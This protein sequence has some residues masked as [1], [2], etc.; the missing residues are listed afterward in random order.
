MEKYRQVSQTSVPYTLHFQT[1]DLA[2]YDSKFTHKT[3]LYK[4]AA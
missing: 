3:Q 2:K 1:S 4:H